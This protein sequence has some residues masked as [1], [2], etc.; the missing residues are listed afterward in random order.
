ML[1]LLRDDEP[2]AIALPGDQV[3]PGD[4]IYAVVIAAGGLPWLVAS[5]AEWHWRWCATAE[6]TM[7]GR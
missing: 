6:R 3:G 2:T 1:R 5:H 4:P 7:N